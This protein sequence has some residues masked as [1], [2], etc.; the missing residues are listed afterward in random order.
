MNGNCKGLF[1]LDPR[2]IFNAHQMH[3]HCVHTWILNLVW[4]DVHWMCIE[5]IQLWRWI[6]TESE[7]KS[8]FIHRITIKSRTVTPLWTA[9]LSKL[10][11]WGHHKCRI[12]RPRYKLRWPV[13]LGHYWLDAVDKETTY[14]VVSCSCQNSHSTLFT[15]DKV[16]QIIGRTLVCVSIH[17]EC[18]LDKPRVEIATWAA[19]GVAHQQQ[20]WYNSV[21]KF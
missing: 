10:C 11:V 4:G 9:T 1:T 6:G 7:P 19:V 2:S 17:L 5:S 15:S 18:W 14:Q 8:L 20:S 16:R 3:I 21:S 13:M 12:C